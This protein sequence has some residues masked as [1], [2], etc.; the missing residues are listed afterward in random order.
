MWLVYPIELH[1]DSNRSIWNFLILERNYWNNITVLIICIKIIWVYNY[2]QWIISISFLKQCRRLIMSLIINKPFI[3]LKLYQTYS[4][5]VN[6]RKI[7]YVMYSDRWRPFQ[8]K[9]YT[10][11]HIWYAHKKY[12]FIKIVKIFTKILRSRW[13]LSKQRFLICCK[14]TS[15]PC[16]LHF[17]RLNIHAKTS[18]IPCLFLHCN[19][20]SVGTICLIGSLNKLNCLTT[21][22][23]M[24]IRSNNF[25]LK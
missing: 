11:M 17:L 6:D 24:L 7:C 3:H 5:L 9:N 21:Y 23:F 14:C 20:Y 2:E 22:V 12:A 25:R 4:N 8:E 13:H 16:T 15:E 1:K 19:R 18:N 10:I